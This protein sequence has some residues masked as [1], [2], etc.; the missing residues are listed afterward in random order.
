MRKCLLRSYGLLLPLFF[1]LTR[2]GAQISP[3]PY[4]PCQ[5]MPHLIE[6]YTADVR[7]IVRF[8]TSSF[9]GARNGGN[10][11]STEGGS[12]EKRARLE[13]LYHEYLD[14]LEHTDFKSL[15]QECKVDYILLKRELTGKLQLAADEAVQY[16]K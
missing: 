9:Y 8:Y 4:V 1:L 5:E 7:A 15:P 14:K 11:V 12:P 13:A 2:A 6:T 3:D 16:A 10:A